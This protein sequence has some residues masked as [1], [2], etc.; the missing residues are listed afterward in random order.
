M[1]AS[2]LLIGWI[3]A[4]GLLAS[5]SQ[6]D[7]E[8]TTPQATIEAARELLASARPLEALSAL[9]SATKEFPDS[10]EVWH[11]LGTVYVSQGRL[12]EAFKAI[13]T[14]LEIEP[15][16]KDY[17]LAL[18][19]MLARAG[20]PQDALQ[21]LERAASE[22][23][24]LPEALLAL[25]SVYEKLERPEDTFRSLERYL[26]ERPD[27]VAI[28]LLL[29]EQLTAAKRNEEA[30]TVY[31]AGLTRGEDSEE[32]LYQ[33]AENLSHQREGYEEAELLARR[34][35]ERDPGHLE[36]ALL[37]ARILERTERVDESLAVLERAR[38]AHP[39]SPQVH[40]GLA[41]TYQRL[42]QADEARSAAA[43]F[44]ELTEA[45]KKEQER[46]ARIASTYKRA[47]DLLQQGQML[48]ARDEFEKVLTLEPDH[49]PTLAMLAKIAFSTRDTSSA[50]ASIRRAIE[51]DDTVAEYYYLLALFL[52]RAGDAAAAEAPARRSTTLS[53]SFPD[54]WSLLGTILTQTGRLDEAVDCYLNAATLDPTNAAIALNLASAYG[55]LGR[56]DEERAAMERYEELIG[57]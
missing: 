43:R 39:D 25:A 7:G 50:L 48:A 8:D 45:E 12:I 41:T 15:R 33:M 54:G 32:L 20:R 6:P 47:A 10:A 21:L 13:E 49:P 17:Q 29:G 1:M 18:G 40:Y 53:P 35:L 44:Q 30:L 9:Q 36:T 11:T 4:A 19:E 2:S 28:R 46:R 23:D 31:R 37:L 26:D 56:S 57:R 14:A 5:E 34:A 55:S 16:N 27:D 3:F 42:G 51:R 52:F 24:G 22:P 38:T